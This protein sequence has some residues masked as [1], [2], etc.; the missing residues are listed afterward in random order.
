M[1]SHASKD[2][3]AALKNKRL[4]NKEYFIFLRMMIARVTTKNMVAQLGFKNT[5]SIQKNINLV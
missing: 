5:I 3:M 1:S 4:Q 2:M